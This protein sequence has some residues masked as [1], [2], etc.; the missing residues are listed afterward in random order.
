MH[1]EAIFIGVVGGLEPTEGNRVATITNAQNEAVEWLVQELADTLGVPL[2]ITDQIETWGASR[3]LKSDNAGKAARSEFI[4]ILYANMS[5]E[6]LAA[7]P[8]RIT[9]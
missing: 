3:S 8:D 4:D 6:E 2:E 9:A 1:R 5:D 7:S